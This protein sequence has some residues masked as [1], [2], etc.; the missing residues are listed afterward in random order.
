[1]AHPDRISPLSSSMVARAVE[2]T[3]DVVVSDDDEIPA[4]ITF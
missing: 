4:D 2:P 3:R 1:M